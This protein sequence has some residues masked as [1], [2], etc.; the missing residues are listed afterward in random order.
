ML[1]LVLINI[2]GEIEGRKGAW[3]YPQG[4]MGAVSNSMAKSAIAKGAEIYTNQ[5]IIDFLFSN[6]LCGN[7]LF[8]NF[9]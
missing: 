4:G 2:Q 7:D 9:H 3:A 8:V 6:R 1:L 5:V